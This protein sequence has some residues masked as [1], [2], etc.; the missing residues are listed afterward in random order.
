MSSIRNNSIRRT[1]VFMLVLANA[2]IIE[3][4]FVM[5]RQWYWLLLIAAPA[6]ILTS[7]F[8]RPRRR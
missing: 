6:L 1:I 5:N 8:S 3:N 2:I 4:G 7:L